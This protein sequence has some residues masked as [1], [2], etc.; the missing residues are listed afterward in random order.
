MKKNTS[1]NNIILCALQECLNIRV[2]ELKALKWSDVFIEDRII[3]VTHM[4]D[5][6]GN[7]CDYNKSHQT[8][9]MHDLDLS[10][11]AIMILEKIKAKNYGFRDG[12][13][14]LGKNG[15]YLLTGEC[16]NNIHRACKAL[17]IN[18]NLTTHDCRRYAATQAALRGMTSIALQDAF[19]W[20]DKDTAEHYVQV[21]AAKKEH[22][23]ILVDV[24][25]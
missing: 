13:L 8:E 10:D 4:V 14:F 15:N 22:K 20:K 5:I 9:G 2:S 18:K 12:F 6:D 25:N 7:Y 23:S 24:L 19:G 3:M 16:N 21:A 1:D 11:R 17:G